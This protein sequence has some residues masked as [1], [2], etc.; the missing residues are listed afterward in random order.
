MFYGA[1]SGY[2]KTR[3]PQAERRREQAA[4]AL[5]TAAATGFISTR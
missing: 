4:R 2:S 1:A 5:E 3:E